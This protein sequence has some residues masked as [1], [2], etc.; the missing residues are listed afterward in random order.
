MS[1]L[2]LGFDVEYSNAQQVVSSSGA[3]ITSSGGSLSYSVGQLVYHAYA[4]SNGSIGEGV[5]QS[6]VISVV[7]EPVV[8]G[9]KN[10][11]IDLSVYPNP[12]TDWVTLDIENF[13]GHLTASLFDLNGIKLKA[14]PINGHQTIMDINDLK[15]S[16]YLLRVNSDSGHL[17]TFRIIKN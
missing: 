10:I 13:D 12:V 5:Q 2:L 6:I 11:N 8:A 1:L 14:Y 16:I 3:T 7:T 9:I 17:K 4:G 15:A